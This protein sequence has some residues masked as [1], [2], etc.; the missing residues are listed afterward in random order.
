MS[1]APLSPSVSVPGQGSTGALTPNAGARSPQAKDKKLRE[2]CEGFESIFIQKMWEQ[3][4]NTVPKEG[5]MH[6]REER[7][8]QSMYDQELSKKM[9]SAGGIG[10]A[11]MMYE[12]LSRNLLHVSSTT[13]HGNAPDTRA[14]SAQA[15]PLLT[16]DT[17]ADAGQ[18]QH[19]A[20][21]AAAIYEAAPLP[22]RGNVDEA[23]VN[24]V[25][26]SLRAEQAA[27]P[28]PA[29]DGA[30]PH[31]AEASRAGQP[32][33]APAAPAVVT[34]S[35]FTS[36]IPGNARPDSARANARH[37]Q[38]QAA[39]LPASALAGATFQAPPLTPASA[40]NSAAAQGAQGIQATQA[41]PAAQAAQGTQN[42][43]ATQAQ[44][45]QGAASAQHTRGTQ[46]AQHTAARG[47]A[48]PNAHTAAQAQ[49]QTA[50]TAPAAQAMQAQM[51]GTQTSAAQTQ[52][53]MAQMQA[54]QGAAS[55]QTAPANGQPVNNAPVGDAAPAATAARQPRVTRTRHTTNIPSRVNGHTGRTSAS[56]PLQNP[57]RTNAAAQAGAGDIRTLNLQGQSMNLNSSAA[58]NLLARQ[59]LEQQ[60]AQAAPAAPSPAM[61]AGMHSAGLEGLSPE[62]LQGAMMGQLNQMNAAGG[63]T[64]PLGADMQAQNPQAQADA[65]NMQVT[66][67]R[68]DAMLQQMQ[69]MSPVAGAAIPPLRSSR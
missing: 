22:A 35:T 37:G 44:A 47:N 14:F 62:A 55:A 26:Q 40:A 29:E 17:P 23:Q 25:L 59:L 57:T 61:Q 3:M 13:A 48:Q 36:N 60:Q 11:D 4:Q 52:A 58:Q 65:V 34:H 20:A 30:Q 38:T 8:W 53:Q 9:T 54:M 56:A 46:A 19:A 39:G 21:Q 66:A 28:A 15:A 31:A 51:Q 41:A 68:H 1:I 12:Q 27:R 6:S 64:A 10:L 33:G 69:G 18:G 63:Q 49:M 67:L 24:A 32:A 42:A 5:L 16:P 43:Q 45:A 50:Q 2:A 7:T